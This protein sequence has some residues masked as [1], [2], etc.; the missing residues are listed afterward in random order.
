MSEEVAPEPTIA[1]L[2]K[3]KG[4]A[5]NR[6][7][8]SGMTDNRYKAFINRAEGFV[9]TETGK[10]DWD[11]GDADFP[12]IRGIVE[13]L[14]AAEIRWVFNSKDKEAEEMYSTAIK[15]LTQFMAAS[16]EA[17]KPQTVLEVKPFQSWPANSLARPYTGIKKTLGT[18]GEADMRFWT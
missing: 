8:R 15:S 17:G 10:F 14:A 11:S 3:V 12:A 13:R 16:E 5:G 18:A 1:E 9:K 7:P 6:G 2:F 4:M